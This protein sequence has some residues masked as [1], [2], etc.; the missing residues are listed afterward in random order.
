M[1]R[2]VQ[3]IISDIR[4]HT[5]NDVVNESD[6]TGIED[7]EFLRFLNDACYRLHSK[8]VQQHPSIYI[9]ELE[10]AV[11]AGDEAITLPSDIMLGNKVTMVEYKE[12]NTDY[13]PLFPGTLRHRARSE[14]SN[15]TFY[16]RH[17]GQILLSPKP[18]SSGTV[19]IHYIRAPYTVDLKR[20]S[21]SSVTLNTTTNTITS[22]VLDVSTDSVDT[23]VLD[24]YRNM[25]IVD[26][27]GDIKMANIEYD[28][29]DG[30][31][32]TVTVASD[33]TFEDGETITAGNYVVAGS[34]ASTHIDFPDSVERY[35]IAY[36]AWKVLKRDS[37]A[38]SQ[39][40]TAELLEMESEIVSS[41]ADL[42]DDITPIPEIRSTPTSDDWEW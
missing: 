23:D 36:C 24:T 6:N 16:I 27:N 15:P 42:D 38:D 10:V 12:S 32:G 34:H 41:Y 28:D 1:P 22:L 29:V 31:T 33:F 20:A 30:A 35:L 37:S 19:R 8:I 9:K 26:K 2:S 11:S 39:E 17:T 40:Q 3:H 7:S 21:V 18:S 4:D 14:N 25:C 5:E 13:Y